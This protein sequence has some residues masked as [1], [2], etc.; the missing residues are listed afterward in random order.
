[1]S[2]AEAIVKLT[3]LLEGHFQDLGSDASGYA[4]LSYIHN[5]VLSP[6]IRYKVDIEQ[7]M[8]MDSAPKTWSN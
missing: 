4:Q 8:N 7:S 5:R 2:R 6:L 1:M 3:S